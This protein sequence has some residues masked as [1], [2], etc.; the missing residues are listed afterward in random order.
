[1]ALMYLVVL[2]VGFP[3][4]ADRLAYLLSDY[5]QIVQLVHSISIFTGLDDQLR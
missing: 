1:M 2:R 5:C 4:L 3:L